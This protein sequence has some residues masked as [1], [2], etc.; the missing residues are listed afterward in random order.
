MQVIIHNLDD[1]NKSTIVKSAI[2]FYSRMLLPHLFKKITVHVYWNSD[3]PRE[4][5]AETEWKDKNIFPKEFN[6]RLS[7]GVKTLSKIVQTLAHEMVHVKQFAKGEIY[8]HKF[9]RTYRWG[10]KVINVDKH[11]YWDLPWEIEAYGKELG[12]YVR[13]KEYYN[14]TNRNID[15]DIELTSKKIIMR[16]EQVALKA[17]RKGT[18]KGVTSNEYI[19]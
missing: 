2:E 6:I 10:N 13:Y 5:E 3:I 16:D 11:D 7:K 4:Y 8:D 1:A 12:L 19:S 17:S 15:K 9:R 18:K 14:I